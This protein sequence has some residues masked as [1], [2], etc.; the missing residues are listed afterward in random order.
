MDGICH[1]FTESSWEMLL[2]AFG[3]SLSDAKMVLE[4]HWETPESLGNSQSILLRRWEMS[5]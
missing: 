4:R 3:Q 2:K 5:K 1:V